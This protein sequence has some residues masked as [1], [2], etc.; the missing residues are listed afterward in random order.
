MA[1]DTLGES[2]ISLRL[3]PFRK[4]RW[5]NIDLISLISWK[6]HIACAQNF[7]CPKNSIDSKNS[8][9]SAISFF[10]VR[11]TWRFQPFCLCDSRTER[12]TN[13]I[14]PACC[15]VRCQP[16]APVIWF[17]A[18]YDLLFESLQPRLC[19]FLCSFA[20]KPTYK[21]RLCFSVKGWV[22]FS[23]NSGNLSKCM[24]QATRMIEKGCC[25]NL[26]LFS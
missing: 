7:V 22:D 12:K 25:A 9:F 1:W 20:E 19:Y 23:G 21:Q 13:C 5:F 16:L 4:Q 8:E 26:G 24:A 15:G 6:L 11:E 2:D 18:I 3:F 17:K 10:G 14:E